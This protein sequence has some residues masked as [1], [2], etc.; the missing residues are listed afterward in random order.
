MNLE[1]LRQK[2]ARLVIG[3]MSGTSC[4]G[5]DAALVRVTGLGPDTEIELVAFQ[6]FPYPPALRQLLLSAP[7]L[8][9]T[10]VCTLNFHLGERLADASAVV[11][12][13]AGAKADLIA[14]HGHTIAHFPPGPDHKQ[15]RLNT[16]TGTLQIGEA[17]VLA[18][19]T[20]LPVIS[21]FRPRDMAAGGQGAPL[22]PYADWIL[23]HRKDHTV[24]C[25][26]IGGIANITVVPPRLEE[27]VAFD[28]G[29]GNM[30]IDGAVRM[31]TQGEFE[32]D[33]DGKA[34]A[35]GRVIDAL[36]ERLLDHPYF[37]A[38]PPKS[39]GRE[40]FGV[41]VYLREALAPYRHD[42]FD[43]RIATI[44]AVVA[45]TILQGCRDFVLPRHDLKELIISGG[46]AFN[47]TLV[48]HLKKGFPETTVCTS[49]ERSIPS[50]AREAVAFAILGN[51]SLFQRPANV[52]GA[53]GARHPVLLGKIT[54]P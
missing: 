27:V 47:P 28:T 10:E 54:L 25:L 1:I 36:K 19:R 52:P 8:S 17:A 43:D 7:H 14:S 35:R 12:A 42:P 23:F 31:L 53:T 37:A 5:I 18:E 15:T 24:A 40:Q 26:N 3:L 21:D 6:T 2:E 44:T 45:E 30:I 13:Q 49:E 11:T 48:N 41:Q 20:G 22:V 16:M 46:G 9:A 50:D 38:P 33:R 34:A 39:T 51:E 29:P 32:M 4:D